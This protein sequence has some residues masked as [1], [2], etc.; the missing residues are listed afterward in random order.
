MLVVDVCTLR[1]PSAL[2]M[3]AGSP[4][5]S[6]VMAFSDA[7]VACA[8]ACSSRSCADASA[9]GKST[10][11]ATS[12]ATNLDNMSASQRWLPR[13]S[14]YPALSANEPPAH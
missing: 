14:P 10:S 7:H 13:R 8:Y 11:N 5:R 1:L 6:S 2:R 9:T 4:E 3:S 12:V